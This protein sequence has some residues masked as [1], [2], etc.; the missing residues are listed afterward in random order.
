M[1]EIELKA[2]IDNWDARKKQ[3]ENAGAKLKFAGQLEDTKYDTKNRDLKW[4]DHGLRLRIYRS[5][6]KM[7]A[8]LDWKGPAKR[9]NGYKQREEINS[10][11]E[12]A[13][14]LAEILE[15]LG[16]LVTERIDREIAQYTLHG[17]MVRFERYPRMD[18]LV[19]VEGEPEDI[20]AAIQALGIPRESF[21]DGKLSDFVK[22]YES[23]AGK[24]AALC[25]DDL[26]GQKS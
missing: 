8:S 15:K 20:E 21:S 22:L 5:D 6:K 2:V 19:E 4:K 13:E 12:D 11:V 24:K 26:K 17:A 18:D 16:Y 1:I 23:R 10:N 7:H 9:V 25:R 3:L 14:A